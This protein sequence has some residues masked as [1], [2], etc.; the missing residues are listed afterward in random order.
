MKYSADETQL[1]AIADAIRTK[2]SSSDLLE[3]PDGFVSAVNGIT[4]TLAKNPG[5]TGSYSLSSEVVPA[6]SSI[7][8][9]S[10]VG[11]VSYINSWSFIKSFTGRDS[12][13][14]YTKYEN[15]LANVYICNPTNSNI[16]IPSGCSIAINH[17]IY[18]A[19]V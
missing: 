6:N 16:T 7:F 18:S 3:F 12:L 8:F 14:A 10:L 5:Q 19:E 1:A 4:A 17:W 2:A 11:D 15:G 13:I 9:T